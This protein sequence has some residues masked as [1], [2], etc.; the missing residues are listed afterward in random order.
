MGIESGVRI[1]WSN[2]G[3]TWLHPIWLHERLHLIL[4]YMDLLC[5]LH[6]VNQLLESVDPEPPLNPQLRP[7]SVVAVLPTAAATAFDIALSNLSLAYITLTFYTMVRRGGR[8]H[9]AP[10]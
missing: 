8:N 7:A 4:R 3:F 5:E 10:V 9:G 6:I 2:M 1:V